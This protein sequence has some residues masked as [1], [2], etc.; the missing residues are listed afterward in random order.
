L[1]ELECNICEDINVTCLKLPLVNM[2]VIVF[3]DF[4]IKRLV[5][6]KIEDCQFYKEAKEK[7]EF[8]EDDSGMVERWGKI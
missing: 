7:I 4:G 2:R 6:E 1:K 5:G 8:A 3:N